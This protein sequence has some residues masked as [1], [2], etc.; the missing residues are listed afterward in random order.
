MSSITFAKEIGLGSFSKSY[1]DLMWDLSKNARIDVGVP[2]FSYQAD[3]DFSATAGLKL[4]LEASGGDVDITYPFNVDLLV[5]SA[6]KPGETFTI[7]TS[8]WSFGTPSVSSVTPGFSFSLNALVDVNLNTDE[9]VD[10]MGLGV[11]KVNILPDPYLKYNKEL[12]SISSGGEWSIDVGPTTLTARLPGS[13]T[14]QS[15]AGDVDSDGTVH[16]VAMSEDPILSGTV[17]F[18]DLL[19]KFYP[20]LE[21]LKG[22]INIWR[23]YK[24]E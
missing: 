22:E 3:V 10:I 24:L 16:A 12:F 23:D 15:E 1:N 4:N 18:I 5:P 20:T 17:S 21:A 14:A 9:E 19:A 6:V 8:S 11:K 2:G 7:D 13:L